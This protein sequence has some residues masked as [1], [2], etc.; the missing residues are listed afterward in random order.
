MGI[1]LLGINVGIILDTCAL[2]LAYISASPYA[3]PNNSKR[4]LRGH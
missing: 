3:A 2:Y 4:P 1:D